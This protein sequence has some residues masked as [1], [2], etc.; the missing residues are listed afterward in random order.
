[1][2]DCE[3]AP[4]VIPSIAPCGGLPTRH[5]TVDGMFEVVAPVRLL[6]AVTVRVSFPP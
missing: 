4:E 2:T 3:N 5:V 6:V 1:M